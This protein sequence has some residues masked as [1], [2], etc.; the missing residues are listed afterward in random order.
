MTI[1]RRIL[2]LAAVPPLILIALGALNQVELARVDKSA[3]FMA[4][5]QVPSLSVLGNI[6]LTFEEMRVDLRDQMLASDPAA[7][8]ASRLSF[9]ARKQELERLL[10]SYAD[11]LVS[12]DKDR[13]LLDGFR[14][15]SAEWV[16]AADDLM[17]MADAGRRDEVAAS[18]GGSRMAELG[19]RTSA[20]LR[21]WI[22][23][24][25]ALAGAAGD[26]AVTSLERARWRVQIAVVLA[27]LLAVGAATV[28]FRKIVGPI[29]GLQGAVETIVGGNY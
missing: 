9:T 21:E 26:E 16:A 22:A 3:R 5:I 25:Q 18:I 8:A 6:S 2:L 7:R 13:R 11:S 10:R 1:A 28:T 20:A 27:L 23:H 19:A 29:R 15:A 12:D 14:T 4:R 24:N 17:G